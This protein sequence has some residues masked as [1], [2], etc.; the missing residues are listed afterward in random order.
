MIQFR[1]KRFSEEEEPKKNKSNARAGL[2]GLAVAGGVVGSGIAGVHY[3]KKTFE[4]Y[5]DKKGG[6]SYTHL[7]DS[8]KN[9]T[10]NL[11][12]ASKEA[13]YLEKK[14]AGKS[15]IMKNI[16]EENAKA[17]EELV[18]K[19]RDNVKNLKNTNK[20]FK[21][22]YEKLRGEILDRDYNFEKGSLRGIGKGAAITGLGL[23]ATYGA[24]KLYD[25]YIDKK[26]E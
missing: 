3:G 11:E 10:A 22:G 24:K 20:N 4:N 5:I 19:N 25:K 9:S 8:Y 2:E 21:K 13:S 18:N 6:D 15:K 12:K 26:D 1:L 7:R 23:A 17:I 14:V 16:G